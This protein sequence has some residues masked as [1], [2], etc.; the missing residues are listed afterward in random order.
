MRKLT[1]VVSL[2]MA[3]AHVVRAPRAVAAPTPPAPAPTPP[4][5]APTPPAPA[6]TPP[7]PTPSPAPAIVLAGFATPESVFFDEANKR[8]LVT[9]INGQPAGKDDNGFISVVSLDGKMTTEKWIAGGVDGVTLHA[10]KGMAVDSGTLFVSDIDTVRMFD[11]KSGKSKGDVAIEGARFLNDVVAGKNHKIYVSDTGV[12]PDF[13]SLGADGVWM[14]ANKKAAVFYAN[15]DLGGPNGLAFLGNDLVVNN[16]SNAEIYKLD[17]K[18]GKGDVTTAP[19]GGLDGMFIA[20]DGTVWVSSWGGESIYRGKLGGA[21]D[22]VVTHV[23]GAADFTV[24]TK[25][26]Q[27]VVPRF[28]NNTVEFYDVK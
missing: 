19:T 23:T 15:K 24:N 9:N 13:K 18:K 21:F 1:F 12:G 5:A 10:P 14:I 4:A 7:A 25:S 16:F 20:A 6:P 27:I 17:A 2:V 26:K 11:L 3:A 28:M 22:A 8:Y